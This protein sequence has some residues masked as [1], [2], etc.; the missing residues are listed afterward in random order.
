M[1]HAGADNTPH[2]TTRANTRAA[3]PRALRGRRKEDG[4][5]TDA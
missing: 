2:H 3:V 5:C 4:C 1:M